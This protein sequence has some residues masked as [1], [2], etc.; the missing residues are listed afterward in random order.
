MF[1]V[2]YSC[3]KFKIQCKNKVKER[4]GSW[5]LVN[6]ISDKYKDLKIRNI[7]S[8]FVVSVFLSFVMFLRKYLHYYNILYAQQLIFKT[9]RL[10]FDYRYT[11]AI[12]YL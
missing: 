3:S 6:I 10:I 1:Q 4:R 12:A 9:F 11:Y 7:L 5:D 8:Y 2:H